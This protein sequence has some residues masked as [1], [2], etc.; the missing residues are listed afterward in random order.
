VEAPPKQRTHCWDRLSNVLIYGSLHFD[1]IWQVLEQAGIV[2]GK[3]LS[4]AQYSSTKLVQR[5]INYEKMQKTYSR[6]RLE[7]FDT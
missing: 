6:L 1:E 7:H 3:L 4:P 5:I 2:N